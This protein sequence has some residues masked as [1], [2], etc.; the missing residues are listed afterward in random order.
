VIESLPFGDPY[1]SA[2]EASI[3]GE[4]KPLA[5]DSGG[6]ITLP[7]HLCA[8]VDLSDTVVIYGVGERFQIWNKDKW[9]AHR[10]EQRRMAREGLKQFGE[11][12]RQ[13]M[14]AKTGRGGMTSPHAPCPAGRGDRGARSQAGRCDH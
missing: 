11:M 2:L 12:R 14:A 4:Q 9:A 13:A 6:R 10:A 8:E 5:Y 7:E 3:F 1:R